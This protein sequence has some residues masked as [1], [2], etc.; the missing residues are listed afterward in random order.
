MAS[1]L[2]DGV[3]KTDVVARMGGEEFIVLLPETSME[4][5]RILAEKLRLWVQQT[6]VQVENQNAIPV[7]ASFGVA[8]VPVGQTAT[9][10]SLYAAADAALYA[11]KTQGRNRVEAC[12]VT[13]S[14]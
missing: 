12:P 1:A 8:S 11:A 10:E 14:P 3:R 2:R 7:T 4:S 5:A 9:L 13:S 6:P